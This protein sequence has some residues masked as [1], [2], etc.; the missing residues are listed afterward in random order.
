VAT[1]TANQT[2]Q[3]G[4]NVNLKLP[5]T[6]FKDPQNS[7]L[8]YSASGTHSTALPSWLS[9]NPSTNSFSGTVP[10]GLEKFSVVVT[11]T[12]ALGASASETFTVTVPAAAPAVTNPLGAEHIAANS[13]FSFALPSN[14]F[15]DPQ[16]ETLTLKATLSS[17]AA[18]PSWLKFTAATGTFSGT[19][20]KTTQTVEV[21]VTATDSSSLSASE[22]FAVATAPAAGTASGF[23]LADWSPVIATTLSQNDAHSSGVSLS[24]LGSLGGILLDIGSHGVEGIFSHA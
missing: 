16:G 21:K 15:T 19:S 24:A 13:A 22:T 3:Q 5:A 6:L 11:A 7:A 4:S 2:W 18:L 17:G 14:S 8:T 23:S 20:L 12:D 1:P 10:A 9:F